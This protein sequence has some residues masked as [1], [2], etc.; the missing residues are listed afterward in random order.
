MGSH[1]GELLERSLSIQSPCVAAGGCASDVSR[2]E[3]GP[4][5]RF[6]LA[7]RRPSARNASCGLQ[8]STRPSIATTRWMEPA[9]SSGGDCEAD[10]AEDGSCS[11]MTW[12][13]AALARR[14][15]R[16]TSGSVGDCS[17]DSSSQPFPAS[18]SCIRPGAAAGPP[19]AATG[20]GSS[21]A[22]SRW[23]FGEPPEVAKS[24]AEAP[25]QTGLPTNSSSAGSRS[26]VDTFAMT[27]CRQ[28]CS[29][30]L[31]HWMAKPSP[32]GAQATWDRLCAPLSRTQGRAPS[33]LTTRSTP[34]SPHPASRR[35][36][37]CSQAYA[38]PRPLPRLHAEKLKA[39]S[40]L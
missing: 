33:S 40:A 23:R 39:D 31:S 30:S 15:T 7:T 11:K 29:S 34:P 27:P 13:S 18:K 19:A 21:M 26:Q 28:M 20:G 37:L 14:C 38:Q 6:S 1:S 25:I 5:T 24:T 12:A 10:D 2:S 16:A 17:H 32:S 3:M 35:P 4:L 8:Y 9:W 22:K 36:R